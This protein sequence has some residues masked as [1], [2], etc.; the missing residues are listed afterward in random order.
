MWAPFLEKAWAKVKGNYDATDG[1]FN[2]SGFRSLTGAPVFRYLT[3]AIDSS[4]GP[5]KAAAFAT[6]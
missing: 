3:S 1:G 2:V 5:T 4:S 6:L